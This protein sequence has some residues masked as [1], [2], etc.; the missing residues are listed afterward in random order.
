M[1]GT[2]RLCSAQSESGRPYYVPTGGEVIDITVQ[3]GVASATLVAGDGG[4]GEI[5]TGPLDDTTRL[6]TA[7]FVNWCSTCHYPSAV[8]V[9]FS[10]DAMRFSAIVNLPDEQ[11]GTWFGGREDGSFTCNQGG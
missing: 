1:S 2:W 3:G 9:T 7:D 8:Q 11:N 10:T 5:L 4:G 6:W